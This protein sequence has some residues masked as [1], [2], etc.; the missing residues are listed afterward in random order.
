MNEL[1]SEVIEIEECGTQRANQLLAA[2][3]TLL[4]TG[5]KSW[6][7]N[8]RSPAPGAGPTFIRHDIRYVIARLEGKPAFPPFD[9]GGASPSGL[10]KPKAE[11][12]TPA[13][14]LTGGGKEA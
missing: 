5:S 10:A 14:V 7:A 8:R 3:Y 12:N 11:Q 9:V 2:G 13:S 1:L 4:Q 6:E